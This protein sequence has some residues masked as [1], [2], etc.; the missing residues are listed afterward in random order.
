M[1]RTCSTLAEL[2]LE[3]LE[4]EREKAALLDDPP[5]ASTTPP[6]VAQTTVP[7]KTDAREPVVGAPEIGPTS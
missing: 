5:V 7:E 6:T 4:Y 3:R 1:S 2:E